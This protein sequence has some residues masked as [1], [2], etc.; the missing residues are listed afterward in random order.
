[1]TEESGN[2]VAKLLPI[3]LDIINDD[4]KTVRKESLFH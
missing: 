2:L 3:P 4:T 1:M